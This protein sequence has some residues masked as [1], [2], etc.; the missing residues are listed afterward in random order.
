MLNPAQA[1]T[2]ARGAGLVIH[3]A[4]PLNCE[5]PLP[6]LGRGTT[7]SAQFYI[8]NHFGIPCLDPARWRLHVGGLTEW[9]LS[10][11]LAHLRA[12]PA[13]RAVVTLECAGNGRAGLEP[14][15]P[16]EQW[17]LGAVSTAEWT[18]VPLTEVLSLA[19]VQAGAEHV[20]FSG[21]DGGPVD[22][23][24]SWAWFERGLPLHAAGHAGAILAYAMNGEELPVQHGYPLRL[25]VPGWYGVASVKWLTGIRLTSQPFGGHFQAER[26]HIRGEPLTVQRVRSVITEPVNGATAEPGD[27]TIRGV[28]WSGA[29]PIDRVDV[30]IGDHPWRP[31]R[32]AATGDRHSWQT[33]DFHTILAKPG[34][35]SIQA[36]ATDRT[37]E[38]QPEQPRWNPLGYANNAIH[39]V[40]LAVLDPR[41][42]G[43]GDKTRTMETRRGPGAYAGSE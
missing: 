13:A 16:G 39:R 31:A 35:L 7:P 4:H 22:G 2:A 25:I 28:A 3:N 43:L 37:G 26:Y 11:S 19:G 8:R 23:R 6:V 36:R 14:P 17:A 9:P 15:V 32:L 10:L 12:M 29:A 1:C 33:W 18:G 20:V 24:D 38:A 27:I 30:R 5:T 41:P 42:G 21:A 40:T 34:P